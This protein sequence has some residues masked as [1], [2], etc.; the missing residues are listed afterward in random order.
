MITNRKMLKVICVSP[1][2]QNTKMTNN[3][4]LSHIKG[5]ESKDIL[6]SSC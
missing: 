6:K 2:V 5:I 4:V 3:R 1:D